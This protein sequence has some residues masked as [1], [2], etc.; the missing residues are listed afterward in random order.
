MRALGNIL[1]AVWLILEGLISLLNLS[2]SG[3]D[4]IMAILAIA[5]GVMLILGRGNIKFSRNLGI[6]L[7]SIWLILFGLL[8]LIGISFSADYI[9]LG[10]LAIAAGVLL[11]L[12]R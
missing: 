1:L 4:L 8:P 11:L 2:F 7:L 6:L 10:V 12:N 3:S 5:A 9:V